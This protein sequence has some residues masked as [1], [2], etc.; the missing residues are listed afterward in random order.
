MSR[1]GQLGHR[2]YT[3]EVA[4]DFV[5]R[6][7]TW[8]AVS[9]AILV[10]TLLAL[11][12]RGLNFGIE[13]KGG[14]EF[15][16]P[17]ANCSIEDARGAVGEEVEGETIVQKLNDNTLRV[18]TGDL[19]G[20]QP[21]AVTNALADACGV[22]ASE[23]NVQVVGPS[24]GGAVTE[25]AAWG[26]VVF[27]IL[28]AVFIAIVF[29]FK[30][31]IAAFVALL[32]DILITVGVYALVG[33]DVT[34]S[35]VI[36]LLT[37]LGYSLYDTVVV[38][39]SLRENSAGLQGSSRMTYSEAANLS[40]NQ[41]LVR[42]INTSL[43]ALL[44]IGAILF[45]GAFL[46]GAGTL[47]D[48]SLV[49]FVGIA[50]S[51]YSSIFIATPLLADLKEREPGMKALAKRV[52]MRRAGGAAPRRTGQPRAAAAGQAAPASGGGATS[53]ATLEEAGAGPDDD[54]PPTPGPTRPRPGGAAGQRPQPRR[55]GGSRP[56][57]G[58]RGK[59]R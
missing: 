28:V 11:F 6:K 10:I 45:V 43:L 26:L 56:G 15:R 7:R 2:L 29:E 24:W 3:G 14:A 46:L 47:K 48:L 31:A 52:E 59:R 40:V 13:F 35:T 30:M 33:F 12:F 44:P 32:H 51:T 38:F 27:L 5:G 36:G 57:S 19:T 17:N 58:P 53:L 34:P 16:V 39:D 41:T 4:Y 22:A 49:L 50:A 18:Q 23:V 20:E 54:V 25:R 21:D 55:G 37:I 8:Y 1:L 42:S 9:A